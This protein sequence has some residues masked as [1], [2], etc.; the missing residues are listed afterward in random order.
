MHILGINA[1]HPDASACIVRDGELLA[2]AEEER[3]NR[4]K[5]WAG[6][7]LLS[8]R[9]CLQEAGIT[10]KDLDYIVLNRDPKR[11]LL[12]KIAFVLLRRPSFSLVRNRFA[13]MRKV[14]NVKQELAEA[15]SISASAIRASV[16]PIE[17]HRCHLASAFF[18]SRF[19]E[20]AVVSLDGFGD[21]TSC[22]VAKG[23]EARLTI[24]YEVNYPHSLGL[25]YTAL[26]QF[27]GF[28][29]F[30]DEYK[31]MGMAAYGKP[32]YLKDM[33][34]IVVLK[35]RGR[36]AL[37]PEYFSFYRKSQG[38]LWNNT[39]PIL[40][41]I[42]SEKLS[43][44]FGQPRGHEEE[45]SGHHYDV[46][47]SLQ[48]MYEKAFFH[49]LNYA[50]K[51]TGD[52]CLCLAGGCALNSVANG[53]I[54]DRTP[55]K[56]VFI[57]PASSDAGGAIGACYYLFHQVLAHKR[58]FVMRHAFWGP[59]F[60]DNKIQDTLKDHED[61]LAGCL[62]Q[63]VAGSDE[64]CRMTATFIAEGKIVGWFQGRMELGARALGNRSILVD[65][66]RPEMKEILN[67]RIKR[68]ESFRPF[69]PSILLE[70][71]G[72]YF[73]KEYPDPFMVKVYPVKSEKQGLI[74]AVTHVDGT[75]RLQ[76]V[77]Q[78]ENPLFWQLI[79]KFDTITGVPV[80]LN[81]SFN[82]NEP[83]CC[84]PLEAVECF[85]RTRMDVLVLG[86][87]MIRRNV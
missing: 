5:H 43:R 76:T 63:K 78:S 52:N 33:E 11:N 31:V 34:E 86:N 75:G 30:G 44:K 59:G 4:I 13:N 80:L 65:P 54:F 38:M 25:F 19:Q 35:P 12:K 8:V 70:R 26:T 79:R 82:E 60:S 21:F 40:E 24:A 41:D 81:T 67:A 32:V 29:K 7:P 56:E 2:A 36:F 66:R 68:R 77:S 14:G 1:Y 18:V 23:K 49:V 6:L 16:Y 42:Y 47:A 17:H 9:Y 87:Y 64:L 10:L 28:K 48:A 3:F 45:L 61:Q 55:F 85:L 53:K 22:M 57:Q 50:H 39:E 51:V 58:T 37:N 46:A 15:F 27:L 69:A 20:A 84:T 74:P 62:V 72:E 73:Q 71:V 83:I